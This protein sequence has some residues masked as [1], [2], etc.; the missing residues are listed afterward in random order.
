MQACLVPHS[1]GFLFFPS[2]SYNAGAAVEMAQQ[3]GRGREGGQERECFSVLPPL[4]GSESLQ[5]GK[6]HACLLDPYSTSPRQS[7]RN[8]VLS[9]SSLTEN[10]LSRFS[11]LRCGTDTFTQCSP[12]GLG[13]GQ[14][15]EQRST[16]E[17]SDI[18]DCGSPWQK[19]Q[20]ILPDKPVICG[21][22]SKPRPSPGLAYY[23]SR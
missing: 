17:R 18:G 8:W 13:P 16:T 5:K 23:R 11:C 20:Q 21:H 1:C 7:Q 14:V 12:D 4:L 6:K 2:S 9:S 19:Q 15:L 22:F 10:T 3:R